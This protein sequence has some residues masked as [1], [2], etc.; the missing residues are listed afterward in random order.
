MKTYHMFYIIIA[1]NDG[2]CAVIISG[3]WQNVHRVIN[4]NTVM[5]FQTSV[6]SFNQHYNECDI[7]IKT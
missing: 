1:L 6:F 2:S 7:L 5:L 4:V 3:M